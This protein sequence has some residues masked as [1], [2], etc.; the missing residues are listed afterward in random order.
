MGAF[1]VKKDV[2]IA[3]LNYSGILYSPF[4]FFSQEMEAEEREV[5]DALRKRLGVMFPNFD[6]KTF[7]WNLGKIDQKL[8]I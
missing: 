4:E 1:I 7:K 3:T 2:V 5:S 8:Q 6:K